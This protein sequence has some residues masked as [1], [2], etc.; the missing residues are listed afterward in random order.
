MNDISFLKEKAK[1]I[2]RSI[3]SMITEAKSGHP[4]GSLSATDILTALYFSEMNIDP[5]NP[6]MEGRDRF[7]L[8]KGHAAPAIYA[9]LAEKGYFSKDELMTLRKFGSRLQGHPDMKKLPGIEISTGSL[10]QGLSVA[11]GMALNAKMF[12][13]NYRTYVILGDGEVQEGQIWEAAMTAAHY[14]LNNL[15]AFLDNNNLQIDGN[16]SEIMGVEPLDKKWEAFGWNVIKIDGHDFEQI[17]SALD[18][19]RECKDKPTMVIAKTI[20]GKGVSFMEN[21][22]GFHGVAPTL[23]ELERALAELA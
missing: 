19:A 18:K 16:V 8:S 7:V 10:G 6:K 1:E 11:N 20:K 21:V 15:C 3:V 5:A 22:C 13:E 17:L 9:T 4:G 2:R 23:E 12:N 14:K